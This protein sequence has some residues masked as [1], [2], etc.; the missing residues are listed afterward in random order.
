MNQNG[1]EKGS[2]RPRFKGRGEGEPE[3]SVVVLV[4]APFIGLG[5]LLTIAGTS[6]DLPSTSE[7]QNPRSDL[8]TAVLFSDG[9]IM[10]QYYRE[11]RSPSATSTSVRMW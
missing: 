10:G 3:P 5:L 6:K 4:L 11:N 9:S 1:E 2:K 8:A 7:L